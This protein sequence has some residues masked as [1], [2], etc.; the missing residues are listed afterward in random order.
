MQS[1]WYKGDVGILPG[2]CR[3]LVCSLHKCLIPKSVG[4]VARNMC[5]F[6]K[7][8]HIKTTF[9]FRLLN[10]I[11]FLHKILA[12]KILEAQPASIRTEVHIPVYKSHIPTKVKSLF[13]SIV[14]PRDFI[15]LKDLRE[16]S[17][18]SCVRITIRYSFLSAPSFKYCRGNWF[19]LWYSKG[20]RP[21]ENSDF[22]IAEWNRR[23]IVRS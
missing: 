3:E 17:I 16:D 9:F 13:Q 2:N 15:L 10:M 22:D 1:Y 5:L 21:K 4:N 14:R 18:Y 23:N 8:H 20:S 11:K 6:C 7:N 19:C 12:K